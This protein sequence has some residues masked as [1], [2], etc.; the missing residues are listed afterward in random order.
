VG[1]ASVPS[2]PLLTALATPTPGVAPR[3][4]RGSRDPLVGSGS[5]AWP[6]TDQAATSRVGGDSA[7]A[8][9][10]DATTA[11]RV[12]DRV[13]ASRVTNPP[14]PPEL[15][16]GHGG[17]GPVE[18]SVSAAPSTTPAPPTGGGPLSS[19]IRTIGQLAGLP[20]SRSPSGVRDADSAS[21]ADG[22][23]AG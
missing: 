18:P 23:G 22:E 5:A 11:S 9:P 8:E 20:D 17:G 21:A 19:L 2:S 14:A 12:A 10:T 7:P 6:I 13:P 15:P 4:D 3:A 16:R 1:T